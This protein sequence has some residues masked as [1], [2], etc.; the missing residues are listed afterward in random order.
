MQD[1]N[2]TYKVTATGVKE[3]EAKFN[4]LNATIQKMNFNSNGTVTASGKL[5]SQLGQQ[6][7]ATNKAA[8][9]T[10]RASKAQQGYF[11][12]IAKTT[13]QSALI[14]K[15]FLEMV[16]VAGQAVKQVDLMRNFPVTMKTMGQSAGDASASLQTLRD[17]VGQIGGNLGDATSYVTRF[18]GATGNVKA[19]T[20]IFVGLNNALIAGDSSLEEQRQSMIQFA[21]ALERGKPD[22]REWRNFTQNM[23]FQLQ[24]VAKEMGYI[25][26]NALGEAL[27]SGEESMSAFVTT[28]TK[29]STGT[30]AI[31]VQ[32]RARMNGMQFSFNVLKNTMVQGLAAIINAF[33]RENIVSFFT[34]LTQVVQVLTGWV[35]TL[36]NWLGALVNF[37]SGIFGGG[38]IFKG[39]QGDTEGVASA[40]G[41]AADSAGDLSDGLGDAGKG[42]KKLNKELNKSLAS[43]DKMN[44]LPDKTSGDSGGSGGGSGS[45]GGGGGGGGFDPGQLGDLG[46][47]FDGI[48]GKLG[49]VSKWAKIFAGLL[50][51]IAGIKFA[52]GIFNQI[53]GLADTFRK[54]RDNAKALK[55][56]LGKLKDAFKGVGDEAGKTGE[57]TG[58][59]IGEK[60]AGG[61]GKGLGALGKLI[62]GV[63]S[64]IGIAIGAA[65]TGPIG[66]A[67]TAGAAA[68]GVS[69]GVFVAIVAAI[70]I[71]IV[72]LI[73]VVW[74]NWD[75]IWGWIKDTAST[76]W[77]FIQSTWDGVTQF[78]VNLWHG[79]Y[80]VFMAAWTWL[81]EWG[82]TVLAVLF[83][84]FTFLL[85]IV[86]TVVGGIWGAFTWLYDLIVGL[87]QT[88]APWFK[89]EVWDKIVNIFN[90]VTD[91]FA[92]QFTKAWNG[93]VAIWTVVST[94]FKENVWDKIV[95][96][97]SVV[98]DWFKE[99]FNIA[100][101]NIKLVFSPVFNFFKVE[102]WDKIKGIFGD[103]G[104]FFR[105]AFMAGYN[106]VR[107]VFS[108][109]WSWFRDNVW[110][111]IVSVF[112]NIG[113]SIGNAISGAFKGIVNTVI[114]VIS[115]MINGFISSINW[116]IRTINKIPGVSINEVPKV[117]LPRLA[118]G[119]VVDQ[120][121]LAMVGESG[122]EAVVP[123]E[124]NTEWIDKLAGKINSATGG[125]GQPV[126]ITI[127]IGEEKIASRIIDLINE[128]TQMSGRNTI[129]V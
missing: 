27:T 22:L 57:K 40:V 91:W 59:S 54:T 82:L 120:A 23:S 31:A 25:N 100:W 84:P 115:G 87:W 26:G 37:I 51:T 67:I 123:L 83:F 111:R 34:F 116:A 3:V 89:T 58:Q 93:I 103:V 47:I 35:V 126:E 29:L 90:K 74:R 68:L 80:D 50:A 48:G 44:V 2:I 49:E 97:F 99:R 78:F 122:A 39:I 119:G 52:Q 32:A 9:A 55:T 73:Y 5:T 16:D 61:V 105:N 65:I 114:T 121:T 7:S 14:N 10:D 71:A 64:G 118:R 36:I 46:D 4:S 128:K 101:N 104:G 70:V 19:A 11:A 117:N 95:A 88:I 60:I 109:L 124:N 30:G 110:N 17:Y 81:Q 127:Q 77:Q 75:T 24:Q 94:W 6:S 86:I 13:V 98:G 69:V 96:V 79:I 62:G 85:A 113:T 56:T 8:Q 15:L 45:G 33:G 107:N 28:L 92:E 76:V 41:G 21:Q 108:G 102:I 66:A 20:A 12:H 1:S 18:T 106:A 43:F 72:A 129:L 38:K 63:L 125:N 53:N 42:A 112:S